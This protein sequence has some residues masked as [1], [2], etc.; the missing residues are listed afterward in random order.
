MPASPRRGARNGAVAALLLVVALLATGCTG[1]A[2]PA[3]SGTAVDQPGD[4][5]QST[6]EACALVAS[7]IA[8][9]GSGVSEQSD[10]QAAASALADAS[11]RLRDTQPQIT[12]D[13]VAAAVVPLIELYAS[14]GDAMTA[15]ATGDASKLDD[16]AG[17]SADMQGALGRFG[18]VC[19]VS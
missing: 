17:L 8:D 2:A 9:V 10:A 12:N 11:A 19:G 6:A 4:A 5:G 3:S 13:A 18:E 7:T 16:L 14:V 15:M 1:A